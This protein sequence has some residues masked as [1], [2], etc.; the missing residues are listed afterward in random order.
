MSAKLS[1]LRK[2]LAK[3]E[4]EQADKAKRE[5]LANCNCPEL[6]T[7]GYTAFCPAGF[8]E[9][10]NTMCPVHGLRRFGKIVIMD[11]IEPGSTTSAW[12]IKLHRLID[13]HRFRL[14]QQSQ[15]S[16]TAKKNDSKP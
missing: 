13:F 8:R 10:M 15:A 9:E 16:I 2:R 4:Q 12:A 14:A 5:E 11:F 6:K 3:L 1:N 7:G